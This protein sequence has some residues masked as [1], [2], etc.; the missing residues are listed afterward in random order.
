MDGLLW[1]LRYG[2]GGVWNVCFLRW[3]DRR[4]FW[5]IGWGV[6]RLVSVGDDGVFFCSGCFL[7]IW[8]VLYS[9]WFSV[10]SFCSNCFFVLFCWFLVLSVGDSGVFFFIF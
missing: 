8:L 5:E 9:I 1:L 3:G 2:D 4:V 6:G 7:F 10:L